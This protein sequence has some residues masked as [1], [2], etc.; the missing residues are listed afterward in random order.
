MEQTD[1]STFENKQKL[2]NATAVL[3][4]GIIS[5]ITCCC[6]GLGL[7]L[8]IVA[9]FIAKK[10]LALYRENPQMYSNYNSLNTGRILSI[11]GI[12]LSVLYL[13]YIIWIFS[14]FGMEALQNPAIM[15]EKL[16]QLMPH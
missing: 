7:I 13:G 8:A 12:V 10:D 15:Q 14:Y 6:Y 5:I 4:L 1:F 16:R 9:L 11:I 2:P 3:V